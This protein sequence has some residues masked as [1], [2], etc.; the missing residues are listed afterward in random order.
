M[1]RCCYRR[2]MGLPQAEA[3]SSGHGYPAPVCDCGRRLP[4]QSVAWEYV[5]GVSARTAE[6]PVCRSLGGGSGS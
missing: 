2:C 6:A 1:V 5:S 4:R 3:M